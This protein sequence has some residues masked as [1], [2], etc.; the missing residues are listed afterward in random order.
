MIRRPPRSTRTDTLLPYTTLFRSLVDMVRLM[1][2]HPRA[3]LLQ[4]PPKPVNQNSPFARIQQFA[5]SAYGPVYAAGLH[6]W[7][8]DDGNYWGH[9]AIIRIAPFVQ[10]CG[11]PVLPGREPPGGESLSHDVAEAASLRRAGGDRQSCG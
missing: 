10:H 5:S 6:W 4:V 2:A 8:L 7:A 11:L 3:G 1:E 9:N